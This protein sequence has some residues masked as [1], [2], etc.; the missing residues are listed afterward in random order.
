MMTSHNRVVTVNRIALIEKLKANLEKHKKDYEEAV[1]G[2]KEKLKYDLEQALD[3]VTLCQNPS[4]LRRLKPVRFEF[5][6]SYETNYIDAIEMLEWSV[7][8][9][10]QLDQSSFKQ[11]VQDEW[12]WTQSFS[13][14]NSTYKAFA[15]R[16][17]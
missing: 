11:Y 8:E 5:P 7:E 9:T 6:V 16:A 2:Y 12:S 15:A 14:V 1:I 4:D 3:L 13:A 17:E 10:I